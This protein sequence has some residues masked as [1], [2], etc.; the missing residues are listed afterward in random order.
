[1]YGKL[2]ENIHLDP[3]FMLFIVHSSGNT[4]PLSTNGS[5][6]QCTAKNV[7]NDQS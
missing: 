4:E 6:G 1:M 7:F 3:T 5:W 2:Q